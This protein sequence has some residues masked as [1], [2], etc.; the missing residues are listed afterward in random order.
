MTMSMGMPE[1]TG[2]LNELGLKDEKRRIGS[3][4]E[5][6][7]GYNMYTSTI[8]LRDKTPTDEEMMQRLANKP[9]WSEF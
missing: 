3:H 4:G 1:M 2:V 5:L 7:L 9:G 8:N 6:V